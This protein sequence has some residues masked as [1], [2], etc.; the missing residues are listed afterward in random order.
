MIRIYCVFFTVMPPWP[1]FQQ[2]IAARFG[3]QSVLFT[4][5]PVWARLPSALPKWWDCCPGHC[6]PLPPALAL[7][8]QHQL[9]DGSQVGWKTRAR[10]IRSRWVPPLLW[11]LPM[12]WVS[13]GLRDWRFSLE[14]GKF[15]SRLS[16]NLSAAR[17]FKSNVFPHTFPEKADLHM[18]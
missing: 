8:H 9:C 16:L 18:H 15:S 2:P 7:Q 1:H 3:E 4:H 12:D 11:S 14:M 6:T 13:S 5:S 17:D 10:S